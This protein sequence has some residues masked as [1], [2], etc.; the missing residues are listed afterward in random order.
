M[1]KN[2]SGNPPRTPIN[3]GRFLA[4]G[5]AVVILIG[6]LLLMLPVSSADGVSLSPLSA[7]FTA[8]SAVCV[9]GL[10]VINVSEVLSRFGQVIL[11][12]LIQ[13]GGLGFLAFSTM[14]F[15]LIGR[16]ITLKDRLVLRESLGIE[17]LNG[18]TGLISWVFKMTLCAEGS[19]ALLL[20]FFFIPRFGWGEGIFLSVFHAVSAFCNA[21]FDLLG[22]SSLLEFQSE[23]MLL[24]P[25]MLLIMTG[26]LGFALIG[27]MLRS[28]RFSK[29][30]VHTRLV[31]IMTGILILSG[32]L[33]TG[34]LEWNNPATL[35]G[36]DS[37]WEKLMNSLFQ[38]VTLRT[39]GFSA[40]DQA[41]LRPASKLLSC[42]YMF[43]GAAPASTGGGVKVTTFAVLLLLI[44][45]IARGREQTTLFRHTLPRQQSERAACVLLIAF[46]VVIMDILILSIAEP[47][48]QFIDVMFEAVSAFGTVGLSC[49]LTPSLSLWG[50]LTVI[51]T[52]FIGRVGPLTLTLAIARRQGAVKDKLRYPDADIMIG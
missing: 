20:S 10:T 33:L 18:L 5:F 34:I 16:R 32:A 29:M 8:T 44:G 27:D 31:L 9:T 52:M 28:R 48:Q 50:R 19:G 45:S 30:S 35:G 39:A 6:T 36:M 37:L 51:V 26:G 7:L 46:A 4:L 15:M 42:I 17:Q 25:L 1:Q 12:C 41:A 11:L 40:I 24:M 38:S 21:G 13:V 2:S 23:P 14:L 22:S 3:S 49:N 47:L 43:I